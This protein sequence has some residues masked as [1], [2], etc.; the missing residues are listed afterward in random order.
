MPICMPVQNP[1]N[2]MRHNHGGC[3]YD[4]GDLQ[5]NPNLFFSPRWTSISLAKY[6][7]SLDSWCPKI[8]STS[9][10]ACCNH[11]QQPQ[12]TSNRK[13]KTRDQ[14]PQGEIWNQL[15]C[16]KIG[17]NQISCIGLFGYSHVCGVNASKR[18]CTC[19]YFGCGGG[20]EGWRGGGML[21]CI[22]TAAT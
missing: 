10:V 17:Y 14:T 21:T 19:W 11:V 5:Q 2:Q 20:W 13:E 22:A 18:P 15:A 1:G 8:I 9:L 12:N 7:M 16:L 6:P 4:C 3:Q